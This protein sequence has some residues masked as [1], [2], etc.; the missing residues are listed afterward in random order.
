MDRLH[1]DVRSQRVNMAAIL[2][3]GNYSLTTLTDLV[4]A[5]LLIHLGETI[6]LTKTILNVQILK[7][8]PNKFIVLRFLKSDFEVLQENKTYQISL[9]IKYGANKQFTPI[10]L[11]ENSKTL[12]ILKNILH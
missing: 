1:G 12:K 2:A 9:G 6:L 10:F 8:V 3:S 5:K 4:D 11:R 7:D